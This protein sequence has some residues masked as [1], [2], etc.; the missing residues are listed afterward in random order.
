MQRI[1]SKELD[2]SNGFEIG[3]HKAGQ[4][5]FVIYSNSFNGWI[6]TYPKEKTVHDIIVKE[7]IA[8]RRIRKD[9][10]NKSLK[11]LYL[12]LHKERVKHS[13]LALF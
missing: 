11:W 10:R 7:I 3:Q 4:F 6:N 5:Q 13:Q 2:K 1:I 9:N 8:I 12:E